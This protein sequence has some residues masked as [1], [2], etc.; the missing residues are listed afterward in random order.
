M[1]MAQRSAR[2]SY[3]QAGD[4]VSPRMIRPLK[5]ERVG[6]LLMTTR[7][8]I[9]SSRSAGR[10]LT[11]DEVAKLTDDPPMAEVPSEVS[12]A[13]ARPRLAFNSTA[14]DFDPRE[15][16]VRDEHGGWTLTLPQ[17]ARLGLPGRTG[18]RLE[19]ASAM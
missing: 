6:R 12:E 10:P 3:K 7:P 9:H 1:S 5:S 4:G 15:H 17:H 2:S 13:L 19:R 14:D 16:L 18:E 8:G 11:R